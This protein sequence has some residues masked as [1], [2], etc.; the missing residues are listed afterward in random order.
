MRL[1]S[2]ALVLLLPA[3]T[4]AQEPPKPC[5][6]VAELVKRIQDIRKQRAELDR[7]EQAAIAE[8]KALQ[9][10]LQD[11]LDRLNVPPA[12]APDTRLRDKLKNAFDADKASKADVMQLAAVYEEAARVAE[13]KTTPSTRE[14][15]LRVRSVADQLLGGGDALFNLRVAVS[16]ELLAVIGK[17]SDEPITDL[18]RKRAAELWR[19]TAAILKELAK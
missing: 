6:S 18:Q 17:S 7:Q 10:Q 13:D 12:P 16:E 1:A 5:P 14:L 9:K 11:E 2:L 4:F 8:L 19:S 15:L 3:I